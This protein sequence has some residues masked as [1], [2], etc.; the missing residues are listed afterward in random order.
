ML[1]ILFPQM[2]SSAFFLLEGLK[3][4][5]FCNNCCHITPPCVSDLQKLRIIT[6]FSDGNVWSGEWKTSCHDYRF[7]YKYFIHGESS[8][9]DAYEWL[10]SYGVRDTNII[11]RFINFSGRQSIVLV[12]SPLL[13][14]MVML[15]E[16]HHG[17][18]SNVQLLTRDRPTNIM[19]LRESY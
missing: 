6:S 14:I 9:E 2:I 18:I 10:G 8:D 1:I 19:L 3:T 12:H 13:C 17:V 15:A 5:V 16:C 11:N 4:P 7:R